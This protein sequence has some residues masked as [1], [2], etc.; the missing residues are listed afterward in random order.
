MHS[1]T[2]AVDIEDV[3]LLA[4]MN[5]EDLTATLMK[6]VKYFDAKNS[7]EKFMKN[8]LHFL[9][10]WIVADLNEKRGR[11]LLK[12]GLKYVKSNSG[13]RLTFIPN[14]DKSEAL[15]GKKDNNAIVWS[16]LNTFESKEA[17]EKVLTFLEGDEKV[18]DSVKGFLKAAELHLKMLR[19][20]CQRV[21]KFKSGATSVITNGK[22]FGP[23]DDNELFTTDDFSLLDKINQQQYISKVKEA[24]KSVKDDFD[25]EL[26]SD[27]MVRLLSLLMPRTSSKNRFNIPSELREDHTVVKLPPKIKDEP[28]F[29]IVAV[30]DPASRGAQKL[31]PLLILLRQV[32][33]CDL[34]VFLCSVDKHSDMPVK[35]FYRYVIEPELQFTAEG[36]MTSGPVAKF[37]GLPSSPLLT[38]NLAVPENWMAD[39][40]RSVYDLDNIRLSDIGGPVHS[41]YELEYL[42]LEGHCFDTTTGS[43]PRG[44]QFVLGTKEQDVIV[45]TIVM[46]N[47]GYFQLKAN[48]G[49][50]ILKLR[51]GKSDEI[52]DISNVEGLNTI[53]SVNDGL[54]SIVINSFRS[55]VLK[56]RVTKKPE[57]L[58]VDLLGEDEQPAGIW[59]SI[60]STFTGSSGTEVTAET[61][62]IFS[63]ASG[64]LYER[65]LRIMMLSLLKHTK[66]PVKF[67]FLKN[68]LSPQFKD[69]LPAMSREYDF[70]YELVQYK[71]P[72][73]LHQ[74]TEKQRTIWGYKILFL[75]VLFPLDVKKII[76]V[77]ADQIVRA[78]MKELYEMDLGGAP[79]A[80]TPFCDSRKEMDGFRFWNSGYWRNH[81]QGRKYHISALYV[82]DLRRFRKVAAGDRLRGQYQ[83]LSQDPNSLSN[84]DQDLPNNMIHQVAIKSL[85]QEWLWCE[86]WCSNDGLK[87]AKTI[88]LC[89]NPLTKEAKLTAAQRIVPEWKG[90]DDEIKSLMARIDDEHHYEQTAS[91]TL[92]NGEFPGKDF[93][94]CG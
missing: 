14:S 42:L 84:L 63:V 50:W 43:P 25:L 31:A 23:L 82:V 51:H 58:N 73:W 12:N 47:L 68:Y 79:Y 20:Y 27:V 33:N 34:K 69:F 22:I 9:T 80:Y 93:A 32:V 8:K 46:A 2:P 71:W 90:Y 86:T 16:M 87:H 1:G 59:D 24:L 89:N 39:L 13:V 6:H 65:L 72:R 36:R 92:N 56:V 83:A 52:Y 62:N 48:P 35:N 28:S 41:E 55:H 88:D 18:P 44:L 7:L 38:Q 77:D 78:D 61:I 76:F 53:H 54:V 26:S 30:L 67:W 10:V 29:N 75:D 81:L 17:T 66:Q 19:V 60:T 64:H 45:D 70:K 4:S 3:K 40:I 74:Q 91:K 37:V 15:K 11:E 94:R 5:N 85:P 57:K 49:A 21:L